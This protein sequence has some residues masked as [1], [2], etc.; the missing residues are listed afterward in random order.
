VKNINNNESEK[1]KENKIMPI[2]E[3]MKFRR[4]K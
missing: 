1:V 4:V 3:F 2:E